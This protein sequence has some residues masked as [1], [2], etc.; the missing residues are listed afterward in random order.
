MGKIEELI[1]EKIKYWER[2]DEKSSCYP[3][4]SGLFINIA[5]SDMQQLKSSLPTQATEEECE[6]LSKSLKDYSELSDKVGTLGN[7]TGKTIDALIDHVK[8][9]GLPTQQDKVV[10]R[11]YIADWY[12]KHKYD[13]L[14]AKFSRAQVDKDERVRKWYD[15]CQG[16][17]ANER[18]NAQEVI[19]KMDL[20]GYTVEKEQLY[21]V[22]LPFNEGNH[23]KTYYL[24]KGKV[25]GD[26]W[27]GSS[28]AEYSGNTARLTEQEIKNH[29]KRYWAFAVPAEED[30]I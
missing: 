19:A 24:R 18:A 30:K 27:F 25:S 4:Q 13:T 22:Q 21:Y 28:N 6:K 14:E 17:H 3:N 16:R 23:I 26:T 15:N 7:L 12:E 10:V 2:Q 9:N 11:Q 20:I 29:D 1:D 8:V 5:L